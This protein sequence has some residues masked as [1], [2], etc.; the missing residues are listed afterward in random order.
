[1]SLYLRLGRVSL[2]LMWWERAQPAGLTPLSGGF[3]SSED[4]I[5]IMLVNTR[6]QSECLYRTMMHKC[7]PQAAETCLNSVESEFSFIVGLIFS[8]V[9][10][11]WGLSY[12]RIS[13]S[14]VYP[15][16]SFH[17]S[18]WWSLFFKLLRS[19]KTPELESELCYYANCQ[20]W[21]VMSV[22]AVYL[23]IKLF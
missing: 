8:C 1:M 23:N 21:I 11:C 13:L 20:P 5:Y 17:R 2:L 6:Y 9:R 22:A 19:W 3:L 15:V 18:L 4:H 16:K 12:I 14:S 7:L 10:L